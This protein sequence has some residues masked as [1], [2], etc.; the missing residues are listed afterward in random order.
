MKVVKAKINK[1]AT[2]FTTE[3]EA[4]NGEIKEGFT[5]VGSYRTKSSFFT[6]AST[7]ECISGVVTV[8]AKG[9]AKKMESLGFEVEMDYSYGMYDSEAKF[10]ASK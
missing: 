6:F 1:I 7:L 5:K 9:F 8:N 10:Y 2:V 3:V 4:V